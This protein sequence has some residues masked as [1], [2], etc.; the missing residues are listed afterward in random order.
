MWTARNFKESENGS[1]VIEIWS[2]EVSMICTVA[3][4]LQQVI[5]WNVWGTR[6]VPPKDSVPP[7]Y[8]EDSSSQGPASSSQLRARQVPP[9][10]TV[11]KSEVPAKYQ[12]KPS[13]EQDLL[14]IVRAIRAANIR[15]YYP[16]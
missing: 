5:P 14:Q 7:K 11:K 8:Q 6:M 1:V 16:V 4:A 9:G 12:P 2:F 10:P 13:F 15:M 3:E